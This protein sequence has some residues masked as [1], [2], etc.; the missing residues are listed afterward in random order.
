MAAAG[1]S[2]SAGLGMDGPDKTAA[3]LKE[4]ADYLA[5]KYDGPSKALFKGPAK[6]SHSAAEIVKHA[7]ETADPMHPDSNVTNPW[8]G[9]G[10]KSG[11]G[12]GCVIL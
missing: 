3:Q 12:G 6:S 11:G 2:G 9:G 7:T 4:E 8:V 1:A 10:G 5:G